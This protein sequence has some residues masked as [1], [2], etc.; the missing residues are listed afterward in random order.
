MPF[1]N[2]NH[3]NFVPYV[4]Y[5]DRDTCPTAQSTTRGDVS[6]ITPSGSVYL[7]GKQFQV[8]WPISLAGFVSEW[9][10]D[11][12]I[13]GGS[14]ASGMAYRILLATSG[15]VSGTPYQRVSGADT[16]WI[17]LNTYK[18]T[19]VFGSG[20]GG[21]YR[22]PLNT[23]ALV[24]PGF[25]WMLIFTASVSDSTSWT[26]GSSLRASTL[27][28]ADLLW[29]TTGNVNVSSLNVTSITGTYI[30]TT[31]MNKNYASWSRCGLTPNWSFASWTMLCNRR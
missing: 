15:P 14:T 1:N 19:Q 13:T 26:R 29:G 24:E 4:P 17:R 20:S 10:A 18:E 23:S 16:D 21:N 22:V 31:F 27:P 2:L 28:D 9:I 3:G 12:P 5:L 30:D 8:P 11:T 7:V 25:Y 6:T